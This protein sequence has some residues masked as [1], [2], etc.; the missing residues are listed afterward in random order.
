MCA[1]DYVSQQSGESGEVD[2]GQTG[3]A[4][5]NSLRSSIG[6]RILLPVQ[7]FKKL[8]NSHFN[9]TA[10]RSNIDSLSHVHDRGKRPWED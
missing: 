2:C 6:R 9:Q 4:E 8:E 3:N 10:Q 7:S 1:C 5:D